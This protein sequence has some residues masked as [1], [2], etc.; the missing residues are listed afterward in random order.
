MNRIIA[1]SPYDNDTD[2]KLRRVWVQFDDGLTLVTDLGP[3]LENDLNFFP[4][5]EAQG[6]YR[7]SVAPDGLSVRWGSGVSLDAGALRLPEGHPDKLLDTLVL[8]PSWKPL[9][10]GIEFEQ[11][12]QHEVLTELLSGGMAHARQNYGVRNDWYASTLFDL[13]ELATCP[14]WKGRQW[15]FLERVALPVLKSVARQGRIPVDEGAEVTYVCSLCVGYAE[16]HWLRVDDIRVDAPSPDFL[17]EQAVSYLKREAV[18]SLELRL[19]RQG[20]RYLFIAFEGYKYLP[21]LRP[22][23]S[24]FG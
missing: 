11:P 12:L 17:N 6:F 15:D 13:Y 14:A 7:M 2:P 3:L 23:S 19:K 8:S 4:L 22:T 24:A 21:E 1:A 9:E 20:A 18:E 16:G 5:L 10:L